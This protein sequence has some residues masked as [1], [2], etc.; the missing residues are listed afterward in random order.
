MRRSSTILACLA[1]VVPSA[2]AFAQE[3]D[4]PLEM[5]PASQWVADYGEDSCT[6]SRAFQAGEDRAVLHIRQS[7]PNEMPEI[8]IV[9]DTLSP[10]GQNPRVRFEPDEGWYDPFEAVLLD[11]PSARGARFRDV[12][13]QNALK[14]KD[15]PWGP[16]PEQER[17]AREESITSLSI[18]ALFARTVRLN[19][20]DMH[21]P[22]NA[23]RACMDDLVKGWGLDPEIEASLSRP[24]QPINLA[25]WVGRSVEKYPTD[26]LRAGKSGAVKVHL[27]VGADGKPER[28]LPGSAEPS[29][30]KAACESLM[31][32]ARFEPALAA[33]GKPVASHFST[34]IVY[35]IPNHR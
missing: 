7:R 6:L 12:L 8:V 4:N 30:Q 23:M 29:F 35:S 28:C 20:G 16:W 19:T 2:P 25:A 31:K 15:E 10:T 11:D 5:A 17:D 3:A 22:M 33:D 18:N 24:V 1:A 14:P 13:R 32:Y 34:T 26:M 9:S 21:R 27:I